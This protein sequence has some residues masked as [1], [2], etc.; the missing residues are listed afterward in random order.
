MTMQFPFPGATTLGIT[1]DNVV[2]LA[3]EK[4]LSYGYFVVSKNVRK[5]FQ[6]TPKIGVACAGLIADMQNLV[7]EARAVINLYRIEGRREPLVNTVAK[8][9]SNHLFSSRFFPYLAE[10]I[11]G[12]VDS[13]GVHVIVLDPLGSMIEDDFAVVGTGAE[14]AVG[15]IESNYRKGM[16]GQELYELACKALKAAMI[17]DSAS[18]NGIDVLVIG[19]DGVLRDETIT[20]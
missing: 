7:R 12:G 2:V 17:R 19:R 20:A 16:N 9:L 6:I 15:V 18:G 13:T 11:V 3:S 5:V 8:T 14:I 1:G 4:R 10:S